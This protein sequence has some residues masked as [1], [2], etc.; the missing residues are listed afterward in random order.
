MTELDPEPQRDSSAANHR[1]ERRARLL[2]AGLEMFGTVG[3]AMTP[4][5]AI[6][7]AAGLSTQQYYEEF[8]SREAL[9]IAVYDDINIHAME[10][11]SS[12]LTDMRT[13][14]ADKIHTA[15]D[16]YVRRTASDLRCARVVNVEIIGV[17]PAIEAYRTSWRRR[18]VTV[19]CALLQG[20]I[21]AGQLPDRDYALAASAFIGAVNG[22][23]QDWSDADERAPLDDVIAELARLADALTG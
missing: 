8:A 16:R 6:C 13:D 7:A 5:N 9:L 14:L 17:N 4:V 19:I 12:A 1:A 20:S 3:Y 11:V 23:L 22:L 10:D 15:L 2:A 18:W 21:D